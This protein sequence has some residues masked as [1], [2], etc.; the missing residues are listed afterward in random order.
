VSLAF[1]TKY[2]RSGASS[3]Y[4]SFQYLPSLEAAGFRVAVSPLFDDAYLAHKYANGRARLGDVVRA[5]A[6]RLR[7]VLSLPRG[8]V[9]VIEYELLPYMPALLERWLAWRG[10]RMVVDYDDA[11]FH[12]YDNHRNPWVRRLLGRKAFANAAGQ[13]LSVFELKPADRK[14]SNELNALISA[15]F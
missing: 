11:L 4:R 13:G 12:Q 2:S 14:A 3:R 1:F 8:A 5:L 6:R 15:L 10:C 7:A 9:V